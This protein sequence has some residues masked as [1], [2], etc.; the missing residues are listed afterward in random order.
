MHFMYRADD[1]L[2]IWLL[3]QQHHSGLY[4]FSLQARIQ[5]VSKEVGK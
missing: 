4:S 5:G 1:Q 2:L 3:F